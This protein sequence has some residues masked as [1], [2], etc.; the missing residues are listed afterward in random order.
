MRLNQN[1][2]LDTVEENIKSTCILDHV[3]NDKDLWMSKKEKVHR[4][5]E[6]SLRSE[7]SWSPWASLSEVTASGSAEGLSEQQLQSNELMLGM[8]VGEVV[9][10]HQLSRLVD[11]ARASVRWKDSLPLFNRRSIIGCSLRVKK[12]SDTL[13]RRLEEEWS[14]PSFLLSDLGRVFNILESSFNAATAQAYVAYCDNLDDARTLFRRATQRDSVLMTDVVSARCHIELALLPLQRLSQLR[15]M[16]EQLRRVLPSDDDNGSRVLLEC[17]Q[18]NVTVAGIIELCY[19]VLSSL[20]G[21]SYLADIDNMLDFSNKLSMLRMKRQT[22]NFRRSPDPRT[23]PRLPLPDEMEDGTLKPEN[24]NVYVTTP[25]LKSKSLDQNSNNT[26]EESFNMIDLRSLE[27]LLVETKVD[28][29]SLTESVSDTSSSGQSSPGRAYELI[30]MKL[31]KKSAEEDMQKKQLIHQDSKAGKEIREVEENGKSKS[32]FYAYLDLSENIYEDVHQTSKASP[33]QPLR[34]LWRET[35]NVIKSGILERLTPSQI[36]L[37]E[38]KFEILTSEVSYLKSLNILITLFV[39][40]SELKDVLD[41]EDRR[42]LFGNILEI[43]KASEIFLFDLAGQWEEDFMLPD[44]CSVINKHS[45]G[46]FRVY[47][48]YCGN[49]VRFHKTLQRLMLDTERFLPVLTQLESLSACQGY[50]LQSFLMLPV[51]RVT[52]LPLLVQA[53]QRRLTSAA[54]EFATCRTSLTAV[55]QLVHECNE[56]VR[57]NEQEEKILALSQIL[58][59]DTKE[60]EENEIN[61]STPK[62]LQKGTPK[63][64]KQSSLPWKIFTPTTAPPCDV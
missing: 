36:A 35:D 47:I 30:E 48:E 41:I 4:L 19:K 54:S 63:K 15:A 61:S 62:K 58:T 18:L 31:M 34:T 44:V 16:L 26:N 10:N 5:R 52:R 28:S 56:G 2:K 7:D 33:L 60:T 39:E 45:S 21:T 59:N 17:Q 25:T 57:T 11:L 9:Y 53:I 49:Q 22:T 64:K 55:N 29:G 14:K 13:V 40:S 23:R 12:S 43:R 27:S 50:S 3:S 38:S 42:C 32:I 8:I 51:Q 20:H 1:C 46:T 6:L 24:G 37:Q